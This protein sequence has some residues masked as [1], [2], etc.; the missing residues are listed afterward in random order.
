MKPQWPRLCSS[1]EQEANEQTVEEPE[2]QQEPVSVPA[3]AAKDP[4]G[5]RVD[6]HVDEP[7][8]PSAEGAALT[9]LDR[10]YLAWMKYQ[11]ER[12]SEPSDEQL[13]A[14]CAQQGLLGRGNKPISTAN[15][16]RHFVRWRVY[17]VWADQ[18]AHTTSPAHSDVAQACADRGITA[19][20]K[21]PLTPAY[22]AEEAEDFERRWQVLTHH[23]A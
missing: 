17:N 19:Q 16:R 23:H 3:Q 14:Y 5:P 15:L 20:Y 1:P 7:A 9:T 8:Q 2:P 21:R 6:A 22:I 11:D 12:G 18:R 4:R 13:S 10:Y